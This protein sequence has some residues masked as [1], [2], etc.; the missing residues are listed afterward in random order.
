[1]PAGR[2]SLYTSEI[3][4]EIAARLCKGEPMASICRDEAMPGVTTVWEWQKNNPAFSETIA[5]AREVGFDVIAAECLDIADDRSGDAQLVGREGEERE[6]CNTE[7]V[8]RARLRIDTRLKLLAK[9]DPKR[10]GDKVAVGGDPDAP[11][12][13]HA[14]TVQVFRLPDNGRG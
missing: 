9:W 8:Q 3:A 6:V 12:I 13:Q 11:P 4:A 5:R 10:Y 7:F 14:T 1:M 2:P